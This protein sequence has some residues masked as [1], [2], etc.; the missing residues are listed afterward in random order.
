MTE[1]KTVTQGN[2][3]HACTNFLSQQAY[4]TC[5]TMG[6]LETE[7]KALWKKKRFCTG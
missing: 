4:V 1:T 7:N 3:R 2:Y 6:L 5:N